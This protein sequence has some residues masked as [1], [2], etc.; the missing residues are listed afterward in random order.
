MT[1]IRMGVQYTLYEPMQSPIV[2]VLMPTYEPDPA[3]LRAAI[4]SLLAQTETRWKLFIHDDASKSGVAHKLA[5]HLHDPRITFRRS[6][7]NLGIGGN[8]NA[9]IA[10]AHAPYVQFLF[11]DDLWEP[12]YL[13]KAVAVMEAYP[14]VGFVS[15]DHRYRYEGGVGNDD[16]YERLR[17]YKKEHVSAGLHKGV[18]FLGWWIDRELHPNVVGEPPFVLF[19]KSLLDAVGPFSTEM[20]Q[21]L[22]VEYWVRCLQQADWYYLKEDIGDFRVHPQ[23]ASARNAREGVGLFERFHCLHTLAVSL[24]RG[25]LRRKAAE[26]RDHALTMMIWKFLDRIRHGQKVHVQGS[27]SGTL[28]WFC[29]SH[30]LLALRSLATV[31]FVHDRKKLESRGRADRSQA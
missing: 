28:K 3:H 14:S 24:P 31:L 27:G 21:F 1:S 4:D 12:E 7:R 5:E 16:A 15:V 18:E 13:R 26:A 6:P 23:A 2:H 22:D 25:P 17:A 11:Q 10:Q 30:P 9:C 29:F 20:R 8:W 19:R